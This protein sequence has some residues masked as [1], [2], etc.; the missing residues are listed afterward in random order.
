VGRYASLYV[1]SGKNFHVAYY[2][3]TNEALYYAVD[4]GGGGNCGVLGSAQCAEIDGMPA[5]YHPLGISIAEDAAGYPIIAYQA[6]NT[7]LKLARPLDALGLPPGYGNCGPEEGLFRTW[8]CK[9]IDLHGTWISYRNG[10][11]A[12]IDINSSGLATIAYQG[13]VTASGGN[14]NVAQQRMQ[15]FLPLV[16]KGY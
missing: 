8:I 16:M 2:D 13:F 3:A 15:V 12:S 6:E 11:Y 10:D 5:D 7:S 14:L 9:T 4:V 1:D